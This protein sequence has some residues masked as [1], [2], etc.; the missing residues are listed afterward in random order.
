[1]VEKKLQVLNCF[2]TSKN[3][4]PKII[5]WGKDKD[6]HVVGMHQDLLLIIKKKVNQ[7][8]WTHVGIWMSQIGK[9][10]FAT[11]VWE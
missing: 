9:T 3:T 1:V 5:T 2:G 11:W 6:K 10:S 7:Q 8:W 4:N